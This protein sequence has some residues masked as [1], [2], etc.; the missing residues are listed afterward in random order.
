[1]KLKVFYK[2]ANMNS[3]DEVINK[4]MPKMDRIITEPT[5]DHTAL[6]EAYQAGAVIQFNDPDCGWVN[7]KSPLWNPYGEYRIKPNLETLLK[8]ADEYK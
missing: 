8:E 7:I 5:Y 6:I 2:G 4:T 3:N 1:M